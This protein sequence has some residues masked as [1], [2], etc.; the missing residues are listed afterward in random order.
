M[1]DSDERQGGILAGLTLEN[2]RG[3]GLSRPWMVPFLL[4]LRETGN[5][6]QA[7][8]AAGVSR[9]TAMS[10]RSRHR[11]FARAWA[12]AQED[13]VDLLES[14]A[15]ERA[16]DSS[17]TLLKFLLQ[18]RRSEIFGETIR[19][20]HEGDLGLRLVEEIV[21]TDPAHSADE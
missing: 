8:E 17:D 18:G 15:W 7:T 10:Y 21:A 6:R 3:R 13:A 1:S 4:T 5:I 20:Q 9:Y 2:A 14:A 19:H 16:R 11:R 12:E